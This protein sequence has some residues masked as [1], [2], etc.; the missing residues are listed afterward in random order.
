[1]EWM[2]LAAPKPMTREQEARQELR[3]EFD[4]F[5]P[6]AMIG[7]TATHSALQ[8]NLVIVIGGRLRVAL[9][10]F[11]GGDLKVETARGYRYPDGFVVCNPVDRC[12]RSGGDLR[13]PR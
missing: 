7:G 13:G 4:G 12:T 2:Q 8:R 5:R 11:F 6:V 9:C 3:Y 10:Q 1:M